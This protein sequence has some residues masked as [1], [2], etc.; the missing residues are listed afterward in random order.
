[1]GGLQLGLAPQS[2][3]ED[4][5]MTAYLLFCHVRWKGVHVNL[6]QTQADQLRNRMLPWKSNESF[7]YH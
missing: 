6:M 5:I 4:G 1:M 7:Q 3:K 2:Q